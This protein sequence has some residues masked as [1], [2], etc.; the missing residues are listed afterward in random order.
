MAT[1]YLPNGLI[2]RIPQNH[3]ATSQTEKLAPIGST[4]M[5][6]SLNTV[7]KL[8]NVTTA[9]VVKLWEPMCKRSLRNSFSQLRLLWVVTW[10]WRIPFWKVRRPNFLVF[11]NH[12]LYNTCVQRPTAPVLVSRT[13][14]TVHQF[15][16][17]T[18]I[19][20]ALSV[21]AEKST[22]QDLLSLHL[23]ATQHHAC[24]DEEEW[25]LTEEPIEEVPITNVLDLPDGPCLIKNF[26]SLI[27]NTWEITYD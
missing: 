17:M 13:I 20:C 21:N 3:L 6:E 9:L 16:L 24:I 18:R 10:H 15:Q 12:T 26:K 5:L 25:L 8:L 19:M 1:R 14:Y 11:L 7:L 2:P 23:K 27:G 4:D 22:P